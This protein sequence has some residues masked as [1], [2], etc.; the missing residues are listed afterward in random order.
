[1]TYNVFGRTLSL[2][3]SINHV[4]RIACMSEMLVNQVMV[5]S[6]NCAFMQNLKRRLSIRN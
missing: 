2:N 3:Q 5:S 1:M 6:H 4:G